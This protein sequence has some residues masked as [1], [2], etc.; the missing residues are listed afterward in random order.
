MQALGGEHVALDQ[1]EERH[2]GESPVADLVGHRRHRQIDPL[3]LEAHALAIERGV[4]AEL[5]EQDGK[6]SCR[7][8]RRQQRRADQAARRGV[9]RRGRLADLL[10]VATGELLAHRLDQF[11]AARDLLQRLGHVLADL[12]QPQ[13]AAAGASLRRLDD[14]A[15]ALDVVRPGLADRP[16]AREGGGLGHRRGGC[17]LRGEFI[18]GCGGDEVFEFQL[19]LLDQP[20]RALGALPVE[21]A[22]ELFDPQL[23]MS[24]QRCGV[25][26]LRARIRCLGLGIRRFCLRL[27]RRDLQVRRLHLRQAECGFDPQPCFA[28]G[29]QRHKRVGKIGRKSARA[30]RHNRIM[31]RGA[32]IFNQNVYP[33][34][35]GRNVSCGFLQSIPERR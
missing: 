27:G 30:G 26:Q 1:V 8:D 28:L 12:G 23:K 20:R 5:V 16:L 19:Q 22:L 29:P 14:D 3:A 13:S 25:R 7:R 15:F 31:I 10:A 4:H 33:T 2:Q 24:D 21:F 9:E 34:R 35:V 18:L 6:V 32:N 11:E 17:G